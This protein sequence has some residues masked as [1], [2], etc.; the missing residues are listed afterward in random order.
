MRGSIE[1][2]QNHGPDHVPVSNGRKSPMKLLAIEPESSNVTTMLGSTDAV[3]SGGVGLRSTSPGCVVADAYVENSA[4]R[5][6]KIVPPAKLA[7]RFV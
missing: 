5:P 7:R 3:R 4:S 1:P 6:A 2:A